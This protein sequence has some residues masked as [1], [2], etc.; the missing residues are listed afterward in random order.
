MKRFQIYVKPT[1]NCEGFPLHSFKMLSPEWYG[2]RVKLPF[3]KDRKVCSV[4]GWTDLFGGGPHTIRV[5]KVVY[6]PPVI[7]GQNSEGLEPQ[8]GYLVYGGNS[9]VR[10]LDS[11]IASIEGVNDHLP[12]GWGAPFIW[13]TDI[14]DFPKEVQ[15]VIG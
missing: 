15:R 13:V 3:G 7:P 8:K 2:N 6:F 5:V 14:S 10:V 9:G 12:R 1:S 11:S 4:V